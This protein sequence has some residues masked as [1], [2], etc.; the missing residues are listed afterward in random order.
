MAC[1]PPRAS[2]ICAAPGCIAVVWEINVVAVA[3]TARTLPLS[4]QSLFL[5]QFLV[6]LIWTSV[7]VGMVFLVGYR[8]TNDLPQSIASLRVLRGVAMLST[9]NAFMPFTSLLFRGLLCPTGSTWHGTSLQCSSGGYATLAMFVFCL[10]LTFCTLCITVSLVFV[11]QLL[12]SRGYNAQVT[13]KVDATMLLSK[14]VLLLMF[15]GSKRLRPLPTPA[16]AAALIL[17]SLNWCYTYFRRMPFIHPWMNEIFIAQGAVFTWTSTW[18][19]VASTTSYDVGVVV[20]AGI[21]CV[22]VLTLFGMLMRTQQLIRCQPYELESAKHVIV[23]EM[24]ARHRLMKYFQLRQAL[25]NQK[26]SQVLYKA[27]RGN[28]HMRSLAK[29]NAQTSLSDLNKQAADAATVEQ[30]RRDAE[31][32]YHLLIRKCV[33]ASSGH[34]SAVGS[35]NTLAEAYFR[36]AQFHR[37][38]ALH[39]FQE[40]SAIAQAYQNTIPLFDVDIQFFV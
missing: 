16:L 10:L 7:F 13:G 38:H 26:Q 2:R 3:V 34:N 11:N 35:S 30:L 33:L 24:W 15:E 23:L 8:F 32:A 19:L 12:T 6:A 39:T 22:G 31:L 28:Q 5:A 1:I 18:L 40:L 9:T 29:G 27:L 14:L 25:A 36:L 20:I 37:S 21:P 17:F 4:V